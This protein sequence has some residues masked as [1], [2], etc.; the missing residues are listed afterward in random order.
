MILKIQIS[1]IYLVQGDSECCAALV[2]LL[3]LDSNLS[4]GFLNLITAGLDEPQQL[5]RDDDLQPRPVDFSPG[6][7]FKRLFIDYLNYS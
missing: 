2:T 5:H 6:Y 7:D 4:P 1:E 3:N